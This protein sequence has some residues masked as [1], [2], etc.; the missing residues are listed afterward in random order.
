MRQSAAIG[1]AVYVALVG[2]VIAVALTGASLSLGSL[3]DVRSVVELAKKVGAM[4]FVDAVHFAAH[5]KIDVQ[6]LGCD[7]LA[8]SAYK[9]FGPHIGVLWARREWLAST[10]NFKV[11]PASNQPLA[12]RVLRVSPER[13]PPWSISGKLPT[14]RWDLTH[15]APQ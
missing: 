4:V 10:E 12:P 1:I 11:R 3:V 5:G 13:W 14:A 8:C 9:F 15:S 7:F 2:G 6:A